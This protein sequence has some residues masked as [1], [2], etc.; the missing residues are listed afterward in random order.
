MEGMNDL[1]KGDHKI[2][3]SKV[4]RKMIKARVEKDL[5]LSLL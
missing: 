1:V 4:M 2:T 3:R 5:I